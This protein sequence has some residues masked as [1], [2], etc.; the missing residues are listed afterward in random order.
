VYPRHV[1]P[2]MQL[3]NHTMAYQLIDTVVSPIG[4]VTL[5][6]VQ[7]PVGIHYELRVN[8]IYVMATY[9]QESESALAWKAL[10]MLGERP[11]A[12][13]LIGGLGM[14]I[15]LRETLDVPWV[16]EVVVAEI[17]PEV[18][19]WC[20]KYFGPHNGNALD[21]SRTAIIQQDIAG[22]ID[23]ESKPFD[24]ILLDMDNGPNSLIFES[25]ANLYTEQGLRRW[26]ELL[27]PGGV[28]SI[29]AARSDESFVTL[30][31]EIFGNVEVHEVNTSVSLQTEY[32]DMVY[33]AASPNYSTGAI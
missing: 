19:E 17:V 3:A 16:G 5:H 4:T 10:D 26:R 28:L 33:C 24:A 9:C 25:N 30:L 15:T 27:T 31:H 11:S 23:A 13:V 32:P 6:E 20:G 1:H 29:W 7:L 18:V 8:G 12:R 14:G 21:D 2:D 22:Y